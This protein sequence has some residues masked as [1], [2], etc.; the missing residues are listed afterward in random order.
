MTQEQKLEIVNKLRVYVSGFKS[1]KA[2]CT[3]FQDVSESTIICMLNPDGNCWAKIT[4]AMWRNVASQVGSVN[5]YATLVETQNFH[6]LILYYEIAKE[7]GATFAIVGGAGW[8]KS[9]TA[10]W[11]AATN[12]LKNV[13]YLECAEWWDKKTFLTRILMQIGEN[14]YGY[15]LA[16]MMNVLLRRMRRMDK[17]IIIIDEID[18]LTDPVL[19]FFI[20]FY[21]ELNGMCG[22]IWQSTNAIEKRM[23]RGIN[24]GTI[25]Y[26]ELFSRI[27]ST[28]INLN[29][30][31]RAEIAE[32]C[33]TNGINNTETVAT[34]CNEV[35]T[36]KGDLRRVD[37]SMLREKIRS[38]K[39]KKLAA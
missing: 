38:N 9:F 7:Q 20:T 4:D 28:F 23:T 10:G 14:Y 19:K 13:I 39:P 18:K 11:Y 15:S 17:P 34:I 29:A 25:G 8:G 31:N 22:F 2:A 1:Q 12:R 27:G 16:E 30:P 36:N 35:M 32:I 26:Q 33:H 6:T 3:S 37:R 24:R 21:N 5:N